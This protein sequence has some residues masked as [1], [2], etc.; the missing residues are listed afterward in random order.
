MPTVDEAVRRAQILDAAT[1]VIARR[2]VDSARLADIADEAGVS[3]GLV[4][5]YFRRRERLL[6]EVFRQ[7]AER[8]ANTWQTAV[9]PSAPPL[10]RLVEY[11]RLCS[12]AGSADAARSFGPGWAFWL[13]MWSKANRDPS[14]RDDVD[15]VYTSFA[16]PFVAAIEDGVAAGIF[17]PRTAVR[18]VVDRMISLIDGLAVRTIIGAL[19]EDRMFELLAEGLCV[20]LGLDDDHVVEVKELVARRDEHTRD[21]VG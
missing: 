6:T 17:A 11:V 4:Q 12:P 5:H 15:A 9:D 3:L 21:A 13:Q 1:E 2:G 14:L 7:E 19:E 16:Q 20:E 10:T 8:I 18:N